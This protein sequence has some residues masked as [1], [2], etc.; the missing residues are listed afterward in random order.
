MSPEE[1]TQTGRG[2]RGRH[3]LPLCQQMNWRKVRA[4]RNLKG[5]GVT[6]K[7]CLT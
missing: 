3:F 5:F 1:E 4:P 2:E 7:G 6:F